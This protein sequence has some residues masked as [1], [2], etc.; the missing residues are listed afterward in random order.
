LANLGSCAVEYTLYLTPKGREV[1]LSKGYKNPFSDFSIPKMSL[2]ERLS[3]SF[4]LVSIFRPAKAIISSIF[5]TILQNPLL[6]IPVMWA[7][8]RIFRWITLRVYRWIF[9]RLPTPRAPRQ[10]RRSFW[11]GFFGGGGNDPPGP[12]P[13]YSRHPPPSSSRKTYQVPPETQGF[14]PGFWTGLA[15]GTAA[16][17]G[18]GSRRTNTE[19]A[20]ERM[21][22]Q[23]SN[24]WLGGGSSWDDMDDGQSS[25]GTHSST[26][27][28]GTRR[29]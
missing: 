14:N 23:M 15:T 18:L 10:P 16:G 7:S 6:V 3:S 17:Y 13:P 2:W 25:G 22:M 5:S 28:G 4:F 8:Y 21:Y 27:F 11:S 29:R 26:G 9:P 19:T 20:Q 24:G 1:Y 12:P